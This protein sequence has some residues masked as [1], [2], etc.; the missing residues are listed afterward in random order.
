MTVRPLSAA[1]LRQNDHRGAAI[2]PTPDPEA[3]LMTEDLTRRR[4]FGFAGASAAGVAGLSLSGCSRGIGADPTLATQAA[5]ASAGFVSRP[6][7]T[8]PRITLKRYAGLGAS[9]QYI[10]LNAP[11]SGPGPGGTI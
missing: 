4:P 10:F 8:P 5:D 6:D 2:R 9:S 3:R 11:F 7:L 1:R